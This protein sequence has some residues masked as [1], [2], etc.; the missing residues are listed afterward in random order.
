MGRYK[1]ANID[2]NYHSI[3]K[4]IKYK[5]FFCSNEAVFICIKKKKKQIR[6]AKTHE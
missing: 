3:N 2:M 1:K 5:M 4:T 6:F